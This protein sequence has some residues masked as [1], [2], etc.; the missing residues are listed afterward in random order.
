MRFVTNKDNPEVE[1]RLENF[2]NGVELF[3]NNNLVGR[4]IS[5]KLELFP[6]A[7]VKIDDLYAAS[8][9]FDG[10]PIHSKNESYLKVVQL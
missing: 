3:I 10:S 5:G 2:G 6:L 4:F 1:V 8:V 7:S 9:Q